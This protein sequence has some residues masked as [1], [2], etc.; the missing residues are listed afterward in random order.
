VSLG[1]GSAKRVRPTITLAED[2]TA[3]KPPIMVILAAMSK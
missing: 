3:R 2:P 1:A